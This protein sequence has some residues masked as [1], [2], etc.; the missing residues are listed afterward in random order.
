M[1]LSQ[2][3]IEKNDFSGV[4]MIRL[5]YNGTSHDYSKWRVNGQYIFFYDN[6]LKVSHVLWTTDSIKVID[7]TKIIV[8]HDGKDDIGMELF[9]G[10]A[11]LK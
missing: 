2:Y 5:A 11:I 8:S 9:Y 7:D 6:H 10:G 3:I 4:A 1:R